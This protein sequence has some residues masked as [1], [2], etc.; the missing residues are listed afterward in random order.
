MAD[1][2]PHIPPIPPDARRA[3]QHA[4][5]ID[6]NNPPEAAMPSQAA[7]GNDE[8]MQEVRQEVNLGP[9][10]QPEDRIIAPPPPY[11]SPEPIEAIFAQLRADQKKLERVVLLTNVALLGSALVVLY[12]M[13][14]YGTVS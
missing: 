5:P 6:L 4:A 7:T 3:Q 10:P 8:V 1:M 11:Q 13:R 14:Q 2:K 12:A 9:E